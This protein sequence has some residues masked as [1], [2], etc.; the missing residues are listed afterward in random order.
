MEGKLMVPVTIT[1]RTHVAWWV[2]PTLAVAFVVARLAER[3]IDAI[4]DHG[5]KVETK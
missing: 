4:V 3:C 2:R 5:I 1:L